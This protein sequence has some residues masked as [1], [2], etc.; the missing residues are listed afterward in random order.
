MGPMHSSR[1]FRWLGLTLGLALAGRLPAQTL[2]HYYSFD[3]DQITTTGSFITGATGTGASLVSFG[4]FPTIDA[5]GRFGGAANFSTGAFDTLNFASGSSLG[6]SFS[7]SFWMKTPDVTAVSNTYVLQ[8]G[9]GSGG[10]QNAVLFGYVAGKTELYGASAWGGSTD[11][12]SVSGIDLSP[13]LNG[14]WFN[15][16]YTYNGTNL[17]GYLNGVEVLSATPIFD[18]A[19]TGGLS[20]GSARNGAGLVPGS[21]DDVAIWQGALSAAQVLDLQSTPVL[22]SAIPEPSTWA[23]LAGAGAL[24]LAGWR[25]RVARLIQ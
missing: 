6:S 15:V 5:S 22:P 18:L 24:A 12:R 25:R 21:L 11:P 9:A 4:G 13:S 23:M 16:V 10:F 8:T 20:I 2:R 19:A 17:R 1:G 14:T 3:A 7:I